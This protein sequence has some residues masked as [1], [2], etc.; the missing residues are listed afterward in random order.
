MLSSSSSES[1]APDFGG[2]SPEGGPNDGVATEANAVPI[3]G[4]TEAGAVDKIKTEPAVKQRHRSH[5]RKCGGQRG[6]TE[7]LKS[8][9]DF[10]EYK[11]KR[12]FTFAHFFSGKEDVLS[13]AVRRLASLD[14]ITLKCYSFDLEGEHATDLMKEQP[15]GDILDNCR[16]GSWT[17]AMLGRPVVPSQWC[18]IDLEDPLQSA[19]W[20]GY[21]GC[22][23]T[24]LNS[25]LSRQRFSLGHQV[26]APLSEIVQSQR[27]RKVPEAA[28]LENPPG[29]ETQTE[30][31]MWA[32]PEVAD[33]M[34]KF[35]CVKAWFNSC[36]F[37][38]KERVRWLK[39]AQFG[40]R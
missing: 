31:S 39:P 13:A 40:G 27:R 11:K 28:T 6:F 10:A 15:Y 3:G 24:H 30:G 16:N 9:V 12:I 37:Q 14:G 21:T 2:H 22:H 17:R 35:Q 23:P 20:S 1:E 18:D 26:H 4:S 33:F 8:S 7:A 19:T 29:T 36:A 34:E 38:R 32:L 25:R 5:A